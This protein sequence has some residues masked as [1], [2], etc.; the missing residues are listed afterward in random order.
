MEPEKIKSQEKSTLINPPAARKFPLSS[1]KYYIFSLAI[2]SNSLYNCLIHFPQSLESYLLASPYNFSSFEYSVFYGISS[3]PNI[4]LP[5]FVGIYTDKKGYSWILIFLLT[6]QAI[7]GM[8]I[9]MYGA[10]NVSFF[11]M[12]LG[13][14]MLGLGMENL[15]MIMKKMVIQISKKAESV[16]F[17]GIFLSSNRLG[18]ILSSYIP[19]FIYTYT[20]SITYCFFIAVLLTLVCCI[21]VLFGLILIKKTHIEKESGSY[22]EKDTEK[23]IC[24]LLWE[25]C[26]EAPA[27]FWMSYVVCCLNFMI[28]YGFFSSE[29]DYLI[30]AGAM[31]SI[32]ASFFIVIFW[33]D[34]RLRFFKAGI[35]YLHAFTRSF[36]QWS[37]VPNVFEFL[38]CGRCGNVL[39]SAKFFRDWLCIVLN[40][41]AL[42]RGIHRALE[43]LR[44]GIWLTAEL[45]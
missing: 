26:K 29:N 27:I 16:A 37:S 44:A 28:Y 38:R 34:D 17:W 5:L 24:T 25:F 31:N 41:R 36:N 12:I 32:K 2:V 39:D 21:F 1:T 8:I 9:I 19:I 33:A 20:Q 11:V 14:L 15:A 4:F 7:S 22:S 10:Y 30:N 3:F 23:S 35:L 40:L 13:R 6:F 45:P 42:C 43:K 18:T